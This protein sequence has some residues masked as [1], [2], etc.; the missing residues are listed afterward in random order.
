MTYTIV[1]VDIEGIEAPITWGCSFDT[2][3]IV[4]KRT[5]TSILQCTRIVFM[6]CFLFIQSALIR[7]YSSLVK[8]QFYRLKTSFYI[9]QYYLLY[10][11]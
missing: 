10:S 5:A 9:L 3:Y 8:I 7:L 1:V 2:P 6:T 11:K 4:I